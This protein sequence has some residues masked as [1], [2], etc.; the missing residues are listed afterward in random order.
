MPEAI[1]RRRH[2]RLPPFLPLFLAKHPTFSSSSSQPSSRFTN[3]VVIAASSSLWSLS[4]RHTFFIPHTV[5]HFS[6]NFHYI[7]QVHTFFAPYELLSLSRS[8]L[9]Q[10]F[11]TIQS[12]QASLLFLFFLNKSFFL[13][14]VLSFRFFFC[15]F[16]WP[17]EGKSWRESSVQ[18]QDSAKISRD[19]ANVH[20]T[21]F[22]LKGRSL[23][24]LYGSCTFPFSSSAFFIPI[25]WFLHRPRK[26][27]KFRSIYTWYATK[28]LAC[29]IMIHSRPKQTENIDI[30][31]TEMRADETT[32]DT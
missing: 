23:Q 14:R 31:S 11:F 25:S 28:V 6:S 3:R 9:Q 20:T 2:H 10:P 1:Y 29:R 27:V 15:F 22:F 17:R 16:V 5:S 8:H 30:S 32:H 24:R 4:F 21:I 7:H 18:L 26:S 13:P 12:A 19:I